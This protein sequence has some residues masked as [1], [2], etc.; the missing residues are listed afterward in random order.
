MLKNIKNLYTFIFTVTSVQDM[1]VK[2]KM[3]SHLEVQA[4][5]RKRVYIFN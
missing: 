3:Y 1:A 2:F 5:K 4:Y